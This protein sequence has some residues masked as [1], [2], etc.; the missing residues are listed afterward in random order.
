[1]TRTAVYAG[2]FDPL[3][4][5]HA[6]MIQEGVTLFDRLIVAIGTNPDKKCWFSL[7][8]RLEMLRQSVPSNVEVTHFSNQYLVT[9]ARSVG[10]QFI[11]RGIRSA[12]DY[13]YERGMRHV[14]HDLGPEVTTVFLM[15]P[16]SISEVS[17]SLVRGLVG[18]AG[19]EPLVQGYVPPSVYDHLVQR[20]ER[21]R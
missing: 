2:T 21:N 20:F 7:E 3:T 18:P 14:N 8:D 17:S 15:P 5:G 13:E 12:T 4:V 11:L 1:M 9:Y 10:A 16:R 19:W 6:W